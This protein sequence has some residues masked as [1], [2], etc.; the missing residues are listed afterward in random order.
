MSHGDTRMSAAWTRLVRLAAVVALLSL[1]WSEVTADEEPTPTPVRPAQPGPAAP[2]PAPAA[3]ADAA[4]GPTGIV[5]S[6]PIVDPPKIGANLQLGSFVG[7]TAL[8]GS[9]TLFMALT[10]YPSDGVGS[11]PDKKTLLPIPNYTPSLV[12]LQLQ[13][14]QVHVLDRIRLKLPPG[15]A[16]PVTG[17]EF[18][19]GLGNSERDGVP[20]TSIGAQQLAFDPNGVDSEGLVLDPRD[21]SFWISEEHG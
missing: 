15:F 7:L 12:K 11:G 13:D 8:D 14:G 16:D 20:W 1:S 21:G 5:L 9:G 6:A 18:I 17:N 2:G 10:D 19:T 4:S 3:P